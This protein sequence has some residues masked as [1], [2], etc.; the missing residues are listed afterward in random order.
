MGFLGA[1]ADA[2]LKTE[3]RAY[4][5]LLKRHNQIRTPRDIGSCERAGPDA[6]LVSRE[7]NGTQVH[8]IA[9]ERQSDFLWRGR[10]ICMSLRSQ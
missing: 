1:T 2:D 9:Q 6:F 5:K 8:C 10:E 7:I 4:H 3:K